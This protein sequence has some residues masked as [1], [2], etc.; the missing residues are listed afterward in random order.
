MNAICHGMA[1]ARAGTAGHPPTD[2]C[3]ECAQL[4]NKAPTCRAKIRAIA[5]LLAAVDGA[6]AACAACVLAT[7]F[8]VSDGSRTA[9]GQATAR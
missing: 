9:V 7:L 6:P 8:V 4:Q 1:S 2:C 5:A 3:A